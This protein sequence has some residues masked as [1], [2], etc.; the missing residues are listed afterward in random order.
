MTAHRLLPRLRRKRGRHPPIETQTQAPTKLPTKP[1][2]RSPPRPPIRSRSPNKAAAKPIH[3]AAGKTADKT[4]AKT[5]DKVTAKAG[6][7]AAVAAQPNSPRLPVDPNVAKTPELSG[8]TAVVKA[9][10]GS[11][12]VQAV[13]QTADNANTTDAANA[14]GVDAAPAKPK[15]LNDTKAKTDAKLVVDAKADDTSKSA[16]DGKPANGKKSTDAAAPVT[17]AADLPKNPVQTAAPAVVVAAV[18]TTA[19]VNPPATGREPQTATVA[20]QAAAVTA[21]APKSKALNLAPALGGADKLAAA[22]EGI[23]KPADAKDGSAKFAPAHSHDED[24]AAAPRTPAQTSPLIATDTQASAPK[25][26]ADAAQQAVLTLPSPDV[27]PGGAGP[28]APTA[29]TAPTAQVAP[30]LLPAAAVPIAGVAIEIAS[31][32]QSGKNHFEIRLDPPELGRIEVRL[33]VDRD[34]HTTT[35]L[36]ADR[37]D[38]L[39]LMRRDASGLERALQDA[40]LK[41]SDNGLQFSLRDQTMGRQQPNT[42]A[43]ATA[44]IVVQDNTLPSNE[45]TQRNYSRLAG[46]RGGVDIRV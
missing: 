46:L 16:D 23:D 33:D 12:A 10:D 27:L 41:T 40:G 5:A 37:S 22:K 43:P 8:E 21:D 6:N 24:I 11:K 25:P 42:P 17:L 26:A 15:T 4:T 36:I 32:A 2:I 9:P 1:P 45:I 18:P 35:R 28:M 39:D 7:S 31:Q 38:T 20:I 30:L 29:P 34:G 44:Q 3:K 14:A 13:L 19:V